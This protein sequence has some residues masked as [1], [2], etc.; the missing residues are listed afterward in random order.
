[1]F[2]SLT[3]GH[4]N[5]MVVIL[6]GI[7]D[8]ETYGELFVAAKNRTKTIFL[9]FTGIFR[10]KR[11]KPEIKQDLSQKYPALRIWSVGGEKKILFSVGQRHDFMRKTGA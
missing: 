10:L 4:K 6:E 3:Y 7:L 2:G 5:S 11:R 1:M 8:S 9:L